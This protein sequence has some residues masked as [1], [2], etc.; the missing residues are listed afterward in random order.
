MSDHLQHDPRTKQQIK[1]GLYDALYTPLQDEFRKR[2]NAI[3]MK[4]AV[5]CGYGH[6]SFLYKNTIYNCDPNPLPRAMNRLTPSLHPEMNAY[7]QDQKILNDQELPYVMGYINQVLN[8][9]NDLSDYLRLL[10]PAVHQPVQTLI[11]SCPCKAKRMS[12]ETVQMLQAKNQA[13]IDL[14]KRRMV[15]N[16]LL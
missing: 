15:A 14:M 4:N 5:L 8:A 10:P 13:A 1:D 11:D 12:E 3:I 2:I 6:A 16:L 9:S 7:L